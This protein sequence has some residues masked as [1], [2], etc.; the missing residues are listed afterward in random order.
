MGALPPKAVEAMIRKTR[1]S[2]KN[3][4]LAALPYRIRKGKVQIMLIT[5]RGTRQW[6][7]PKGWPMEALKP[8]KAAAQEA[9]E[10]AGIVGTI[11]KHCLGQYRYR[12][13]RGPLYGQKI[14][15]LVFALQVEK[16]AKHFP[17][18]GQRQ[19]KWMS[20][21]KA[22]K[23]IRIPELAEIVRDFAP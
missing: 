17:E 15:V 4:Q 8:H 7:I 14:R 5:S 20:P 18:A 10:E 23:Q 21:Q 13:T 19:R 2:G 12:K 16:C 11:E 3:I 6:I 1:K 9:W 22:A